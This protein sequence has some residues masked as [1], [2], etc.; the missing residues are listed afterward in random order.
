MKIYWR[1]LLSALWVLL[2]LFLQRAQSAWCQTLDTAKLIEG[3]KK[4]GA[5]LIYGVTDLRQANLV[6]GKFREKY[7]FI[8]AKFNR[9][10][11]DYHARLVAEEKSGKYLAD[12]LQNNSL[13]LYF[14]K[15]AGLFAYYFPP[16]TATIPKSLKTRDTGR[17]RTSIFTFLPITPK[18]LRAPSC[19]K[20]GK[21]Y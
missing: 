4:E 19:R 3:A 6:L 8:D 5:L 10:P 9:F 13:G 11:D 2:G 18:R 14:L 17:Q 16:K 21:S 15:K 12:V 7:P 1:V 20:R